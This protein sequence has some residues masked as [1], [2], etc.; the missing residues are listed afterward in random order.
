[1]STA[2][3]NT[4]DLIL[5]IGGVVLL[6][7]GGAW[8]ALKQPWSDAEPVT[9]APVASP[10]T[11]TGTEVLPAPAAT[12]ERQ[13]LLERAALARQ[14]GFVFEPEQDGAWGL[15]L[16]ARARWGSDPQVEQALEEL[17]G[18]LL[19][20]AD[21]AMNQGRLEVALEELTRLD[22]ADVDHPD[23]A[24][25]R[26]RFARQLD[27]LLSLARSHAEQSRWDEAEQALA[28]AASLGAGASA[29]AAVNAEL[30]EARERSEAE[31]AARS[32]AEAA[33]PEPPPIDPLEMLLARFETALDTDRLLAPQ[34]DNARQHLLAARQLGDD[35]ERVQEAT[36]RLNERLLAAT[37]QAI[38]RDELQEA[39]G[40]LEAA[41][42]LGANSSG[43]DGLRTQL[44]DRL[45]AAESRR[46]LPITSLTLVNYVA[47]AYP[48]SAVRG[49]TEGWVD[50]EFTVTEE[51][52][53]DSIEVVASSHDRLFRNESVR[54]VSQWEFEPRSYRG[55]VI[56]Q[57][58]GTRLS[59][60]LQDQ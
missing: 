15:Y 58:T 36:L 6:A 50:V 13:N 48:V 56:P 1:M 23:A 11:D 31:A 2:Q 29:T 57:R 27:G 54:A 19:Q 52:R 38:A 49:H 34:P 32:E 26:A 20:R 9:D 12:D 22:T 25:T 40:W 41:E 14:A 4:S 16:E 35:D 39:E 17:A 8:L 5:I 47:P 37:R 44:E 42:G 59:F 3:R 10:A 7:V 18:T 33:T 30:L 51:G 43:T 60:R 21:V 53:T 55:R 28:R 46:V 45:A 24:E